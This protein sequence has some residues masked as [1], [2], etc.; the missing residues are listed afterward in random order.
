MVKWQ[1]LRYIDL[2]CF[3]Q[4]SWPWRG[5]SPQ[6]HLSLPGAKACLGL[7][8]IPANHPG[9]GDLEPPIQTHTGPH[10]TTREVRKHDPTRLRLA[11]GTR[12]RKCSHFTPTGLPKIHLGQLHRSPPAP[13]HFS[14]TALSN[15]TSCDE[16]N[17]LFTV[18]L[19]G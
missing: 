17:A 1:S 18:S 12:D 15:G 5:F 2:I 11:M 7:S 4:Y 8:H 14:R 6:H 9:T 3:L 13:K 10:Q 19:H 16:E